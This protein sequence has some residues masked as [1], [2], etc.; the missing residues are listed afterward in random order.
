VELVL[1]ALRRLTVALGFTLTSALL[2]SGFV[3]AAA[4]PAVATV[5]VRAVAKRAM[6]VAA[7]PSDVNFMVGVL[8]Y[9]RCG[10]LIAV[11]ANSIEGRWS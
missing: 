8:P 11:S 9:V 2:Q 5:P 3:A 4:V 10:L 1:G 7:V 6:A